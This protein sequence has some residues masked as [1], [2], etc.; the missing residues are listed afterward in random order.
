MPVYVPGKIFFVRWEIWPLTVSC[1]Q[2]ACVIPLP[3]PQTILI[4]DDW[5]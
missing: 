3:V 5:S 1:F 2:A 4:K